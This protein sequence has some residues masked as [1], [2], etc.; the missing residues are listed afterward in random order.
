MSDPF[1]LLFQAIL[2]TLGIGWCYAVAQRRREHVAELR[3]GEVMIAKIV[4]VGL[5]LVTAVVAFFT[6]SVIIRL[7]LDIVEGI[8][9]LL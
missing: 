8:R 3:E 1:G 5:W 4:I 9:N 6:A 7:V 2:L